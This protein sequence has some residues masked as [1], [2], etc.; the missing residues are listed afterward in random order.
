MRPAKSNL[1]TS[2]IAVLLPALFCQ[3]SQAAATRVFMAQQAAPQPPPYQN[4]ARSYDFLAHRTRQGRTL[5]AM[6]AS[7]TTPTRV[8]YPQ[9]LPAVRCAMWKQLMTLSTVVLFIPASSLWSPQTLTQEA[10]S[11]ESKIPAEAAKQAN[12]VKSTPVTLARAK[13]VYGFDCAMCHGITGD[14]KGDLADSMKLKLRDYRD[15]AAL[16]DLTDGELFFIIT[17]GKGKMPDEGT[18]MKPEEIWNMVNYLRSFAEK[19]AS[20]KSK[21]PN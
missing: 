2:N 1:C 6:I 21:E 15:S 14:G 3:R 7:F 5:A 10:S 8:E 13:K 17:K 12:P 18:R 9:N 20:T 19:T 16:K 4:Q 11:T